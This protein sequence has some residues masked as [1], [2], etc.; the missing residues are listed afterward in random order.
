MTLIN[1]YKKD[2]KRW[3]HWITYPTHKYHL[4]ISSLR[5]CLDQLLQRSSTSWLLITLVGPSLHSCWLP[6]ENSTWMFLRLLTVHLL[7]F[8]SWARHNFLTLQQVTLYQ[9]LMSLNKI[10]KMFAPLTS[11][12]Y[13]KLER[14]N[15]N[16]SSHNLN[17]GLG[18]RYFARSL[19]ISKW[20]ILK[21]HC[22]RFALIA[23]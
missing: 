21:S 2:I 19:F 11:K 9:R 1:N 3:K 15:I 18:I 13:C 14:M 17:S 4:L 23:L 12:W 7:L 10:R 16:S 5:F 8:Q 6:S 22:E 20:L